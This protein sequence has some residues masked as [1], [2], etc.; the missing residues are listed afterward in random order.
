MSQVTEG[1]SNPADQVAAEPVTEVEPTTLESAVLLVGR[2]I[3]KRRLSDT[4]ASADCDSGEV[5]AVHADTLETGS[6]QAGVFNCGIVYEL[7]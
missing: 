4:T 2:T 7:R 6:S 3:R 1:P 5:T